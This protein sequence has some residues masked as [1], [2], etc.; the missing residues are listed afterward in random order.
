M[1]STFI[2]H[3]LTLSL[4]AAVLTSHAAYAAEQG[5]SGTMTA[6]E[7]RYRLPAPLPV[8]DGDSPNLAG[9]GKSRVFA[10][11]VQPQEHVLATGV[12]TAIRESEGYQA[13]Q[14]QGV[15]TEGIVL[16]IGKDTIIQLKDGT[17]LS[18][19]DLHIGL[20]VEAEHSQVSTLSLPPQTAA[21]KITVLDKDGPQ[22]LLGTAGGIT[23]VKTANHG[24]SLRV[25]GEGL[26]AKSPA[27]VILRV[28]DAT[29]LL[30]KEAEPVKADTLV[31]G[32]RI[33]AFYPPLLTKSMP[34][35]GTA[36]KIVVEP[37]TE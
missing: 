6:P 12:I 30:N 4:A 31:K 35:I 16:N 28:T 8:G 17:R 11:P 7:Q 19:R 18:F 27:E 23:E 9:T 15:N 3:L 26:N 37:A 10:A 24:V 25:K 36:W 29:L 21:Y 32:A 5:N 13:I 1:K 34:P 33:I 14:I 22:E 20:T 2:A